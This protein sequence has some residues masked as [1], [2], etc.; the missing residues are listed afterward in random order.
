MSTRV[1]SSE[2]GFVSLRLQ[3][4]MVSEQFS[5]LSLVDSSAL[6]GL[7]WCMRWFIR[8]GHALSAFLGHCARGF[9]LIPGYCLTGNHYVAR[10][11]QFISQF[12]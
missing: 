9:L 5:S 1:K 4:Y 3:T 2:C 6:S 12:D 10:F 7:F 11:V 8:N